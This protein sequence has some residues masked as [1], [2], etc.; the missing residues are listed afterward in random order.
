MKIKGILFATLSVFG[1]SGAFAQGVEYDDM[2]FNAEDRA[3]LNAQRSM[4]VAYTA[5][6][7]SKKSDFNE[8]RGNPTDSYSARN[9]NPE[10]TSREHSQTAQSDEEDYFVNNYQY[11]RNQLNNWN[12]DFS[13]WYQNP[14]YRNNFYGPSINSWNSPYY[15]YNSWNSPW[16][17]PYWSY[18]GM[19][20][21]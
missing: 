13:N 4:E 21:S 16:Y 20:S 2:Y 18:N 12:N 17:D 8:E 7:R 14:W 11:N 9:V 5:P 1:I 3:K 15:G 10:Y 6:S 19:S